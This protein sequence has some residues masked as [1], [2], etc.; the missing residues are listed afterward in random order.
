MVLDFRYGFVLFFFFCWS[1]LVFCDELIIIKVWKRIGKFYVDWYDDYC[2]GLGF[3][4]VNV[5]VF[6]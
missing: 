2:L 5:G 3:W 1:V 6:V 4:K